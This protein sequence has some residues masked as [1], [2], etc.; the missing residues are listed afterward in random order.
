[1]QDLDDAASELAGLLPSH[2][3]FGPQDL[4]E[5]L[6][7]R[8]NVRLRSV[9]G[10]PAPAETARMAQERLLTL[11]AQRDKLAKMRKEVDAA[12]KELKSL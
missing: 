8:S 9:I 3:G 4:K 6:D 11:E 1:M 2:S 5:A 12:L 7:P 10:G